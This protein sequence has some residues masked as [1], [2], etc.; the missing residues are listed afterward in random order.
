MNCV[1]QTYA[2]RPACEYM[3]VFPVNNFIWLITQSA[4][5][6]AEA[7]PLGRGEA[8]WGMLWRR[9]LRPSRPPYCKLAT[10]RCKAWESLQAAMR[11]NREPT[12]TARKVAIA[13]C[14]VALLN[15]DS[16]KVQRTPSLGGGHNALPL[17]LPLWLLLWQ[18]VQ[19][20]MPVGGGA[21]PV[22]S[23]RVFGSSWENG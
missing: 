15:L 12:T 21:V 18:T 9:V 11:V 6:G 3:A 14:N 1:L 17:W 4:R 16:L 19:D 22:L 8:P 10:R 5:W 23:I 7:V 20:V 13:T 2:I